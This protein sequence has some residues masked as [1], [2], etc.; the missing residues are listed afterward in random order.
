MARTVSQVAGIAGI[1]VRTLHHYDETSTCPRRW[2]PPR[3]TAS[4]ANIDKTAPGLAEY[5]A[6]AFAANA[7]R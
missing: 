3:R 6:K 2:T 1:S 4:T 5:A 7:G